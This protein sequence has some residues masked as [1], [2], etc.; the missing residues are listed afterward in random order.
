M[1]KRTDKQILG[2]KSENIAAEWLEERG[3]KILERNFTT[4]VGE[5]DIIAFKHNVTYF[6]EVRSRSGIHDPG[7]IAESVSLKK[8]RRITT[9]AQIYLSLHRKQEEHFIIQILTICWVDDIR[10]TIHC[11][12]V[13]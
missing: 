3:Y 4:K 11:V 5:I 10:C 2:R 7:S 9:S 1:Q 8:L 12:P 13:Q 6:I